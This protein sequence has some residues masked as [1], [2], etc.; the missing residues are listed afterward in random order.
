MIE[1]GKAQSRGADVANLVTQ[2]RRELVMPYAGAGTPGKAL[3]FFS[4][5]AK[6]DEQ[7]YDMFERLA[8]L[9]FDTG[10]WDAII[11]VYH[12]LMGE[13]SDSDKVCYWQTRVTNAR[14]QRRQ[15]EGRHGGRA[16]DRPVRHLQGRQAQG[17]GQEDLQAGVGRHADR[18]RD[19]LAP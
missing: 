19:R 13:Q 5:Y 18:P 4:R 2:S 15:E 1:F 16:P 11:A 6:D 17:R 8:E 7:A 12:K 3:E 10:Q 9:Y 14:R